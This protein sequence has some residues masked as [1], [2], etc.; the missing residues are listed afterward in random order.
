MRCHFLAAVI[1]VVFA[2]PA[3]AQDMMSGPDKGGA[4]PAL[5]VFDATGAFKDKE[6]DYAA[7]RKDKLT[8]YLFISAE[9][10]DR[11]MNRFMKGL[12]AAVGKDQKK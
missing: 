4:V 11:P 10:F 6:T 3:L 8:V 5:K 7:E 1:A 9:K 2:Q 12:D